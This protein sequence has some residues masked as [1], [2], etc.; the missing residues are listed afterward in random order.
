MLSTP[1]LGGNICGKKIL[2]VEAFYLSQAVSQGFAFGFTD[3]LKLLFGYYIDQ[4][5]N[6]NKLA[7]QIT[8][9][10]FMNIDINHSLVSNQIISEN[11]CQ[12]VILHQT[13]HLF[14]LRYGSEF[15]GSRIWVHGITALYLNEKIANAEN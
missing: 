10:T 6:G 15:R 12:D 8:G 13:Q 4:V 3:T 14:L 2:N 7:R 11:L 5:G 1:G 9:Y